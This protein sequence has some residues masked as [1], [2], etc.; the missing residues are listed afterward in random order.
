MRITSITSAAPTV[1]GLPQY[2]DLVSSSNA[3]GVNVTNSDGGVGDGVQG[4]IERSGIIYLYG[5]NT[6]KDYRI[7]AVYLCNF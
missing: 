4:Y 3:V 6:S 5:C 1:T 2:T 7:H